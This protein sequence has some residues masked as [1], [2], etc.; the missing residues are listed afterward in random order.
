MEA[1]DDFVENC[2][3][4]REFKVFKDYDWTH[5]VF[6]A[7]PFDPALMDYAMITSDVYL[8]NGITVYSRK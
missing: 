1:Y 7:N 5:G 3:D 8:F 6:T 4:I 2:S